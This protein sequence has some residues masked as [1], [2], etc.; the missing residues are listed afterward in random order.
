M[1]KNLRYKDISDESMPCGWSY[2][3][4]HS[5]MYYLICMPCFMGGHAIGGR[6][7][8][9]GVHPEVGGGVQGHGT[10]PKFLYNFHDIS[11]AKR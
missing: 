5:R 7:V 10:S 6:D 1:N 11:R 9:G 3:I 4:H 2:C 8:R